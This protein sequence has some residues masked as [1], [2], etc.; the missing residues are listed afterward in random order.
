MV[1]LLIYQINYPGRN[2]FLDRF[3]NCE[4]DKVMLN[5]HMQLPNEISLW[6]LNPDNI[7][8]KEGAR[9]FN[10]GNGISICIEQKQ[11]KEIFCFYSSYNNSSI[12]QFYI[13][14]IDRLKKFCH[15]FKD[16]MAY[17]L[18]NK[19]LHRMVVPEYYIEK[20]ITVPAQE[21]IRKF[22][23]EIDGGYSLLEEKI[24]RNLTK[25]EWACIM[26][27][28]Q[29]ESAKVVAD[30]LCLSKRTVETHLNNAKIK[31]NCKNI[32]ELMYVVTRSYCI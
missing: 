21:N 26:R 1:L 14:N 3:I 6:S 9:Q 11:Y 31:L 27:S 23:C 8:W 24:T 18:D 13:N 12:N 7:I 10:Y 16:K 20:K 28:A 25:Q 30:R 32:C 2:I 17:V 15:Y 5:A 19:N 4:Y 22:L 29:G